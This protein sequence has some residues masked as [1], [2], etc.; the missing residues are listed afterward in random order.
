MT[1]GSSLTGNAQL[2]DSGIHWQ[3]GTD[4]YIDSI[5]P[6]ANGKITSAMV[7][8]TAGDT[9]APADDASDQDWHQGHFSKYDCYST[10][11]WPENAGTIHSNDEFALQY[12]GTQPT[13]LTN[14]KFSFQVTGYYPR[15]EK[16]KTWIYATGE[17]ETTWV[18]P[19]GTD[20]IMHINRPCGKM[21]YFYQTDFGK[22]TTRLPDGASQDVSNPW[23]IETLNDDTGNYMWDVGN[24]P[25]NTIVTT[26]TADLDG[27]PHTPEE[28]IKN[29]WWVPCLYTY[30]SNPIFKASAVG[31]VDKDGRE[32][33]EWLGGQKLNL[34]PKML[35]RTINQV[36]IGCHIMWI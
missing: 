28:Q 20:L 21:N 36:N 30:G 12:A 4:A 13:S 35:L 15:V 16:L 1:S 5:S 9:V 8:H 27:D 34:Y 29:V 14:P 7:C 6:F 2:Q 22:A 32:F 25:L 11:F 31:E 26:D 17:S 33:S 19:M 18:R 3:D 23:R 24:L 10:I